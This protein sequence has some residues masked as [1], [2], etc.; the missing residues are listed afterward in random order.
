[1]HA[2]VGDMFHGLSN[3]NEFTH[4]C[5]INITEKLCF[6]Y[7]NNI[8]VVEQH[9]KHKEMILFLTDPEKLIWYCVMSDTL[10]PAKIVCFNMMISLMERPYSGVMWHIVGT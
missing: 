7:C 3:R 2:L 9:I 8:K 5:F 1:M 6:G 10:Y 4:T